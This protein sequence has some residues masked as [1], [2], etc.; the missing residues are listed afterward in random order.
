MSKHIWPLCPP[1]KA[2]IND[3]IHELPD[4]DVENSDILQ[5]ISLPQVNVLVVMTPARVLAYNLKPLALVAAH[6]RS[7][8][9]I[10]EFGLNRSLT[11]S[12]ALDRDVEGLLSK[13]ESYSI[14]W[15]QGKMVFYV[16]TDRNFILTYQILKGSTNLATFKDY[17]IPVIDTQ[18]VRDDIDQDYDDALDNDTLTV[19]EK[20]KT[21]RI[22]QNGY[23]VRKDK[24]FLQFLAVKQ[25]DVDELPVRKL[26][27]RLKVVLKFDHNITDLFGFKRSIEGNYGKAEESL[28]VLFP[29]GL[30]LLS[31]EDFKLKRT[32]LVEVLNG[33]KICLNDGHVSVISKDSDEKDTIINTVIFSNQSIESTKL[34]DPGTFLSCFELGKR[35]VLLFEDKVTF[36]NTI[37]KE[38]DHAFDVPFKVKLGGKMN[39]QILLLISS[40]NS[41]HFITPYGNSIF[42]SSADSDLGKAPKTLD[43]SDFAYVDKL[44]IIVSHSGDYEMWDLWEEA[45]QTPSDSRSPASYVLHNNNNDIAIYSPLGSSPMRNDFMQMIKLPTKTINNCVPLIKVSSD[46]RLMAVY[47]SNKNMLLI[48][49]LETNVWYNFADLAVVDMH[50][51][52]SSYLLCQIKKEDGA[53][54]VQCFRFHLQDLDTSDIV[55]YRVWEHEIPASVAVVK[56]QVNVSNKYRLLKIKSRESAE[57]EKYA[58]K[59]Y[60]TAEIIIIAGKEVSIIA[61]LSIIHPSGVNIIKKFHEQTK[62]EVP[63]LTAAGSI[64]WMSSFKEGLL[65]YYDNKIMRIGALNAESPQEEI[66]LQNVE[67]IIDF[68][69]DEVYLVSKTQKLFYKL[70]DLWEGKPPMLSIPLEDDFYPISISS[71]TTTTHGLNCVYHDNYAKLVI[72][73]KI[74]LDRIITAKMEQN[75]S[76]K[77]ILAEFGLIRHYKFALEKILS[78]KIL[79]NEPLDQI[80]ELIK[81]CDSP[82]DSD[83]GLHASQSGT[84]EIVSNCLRK[85]E[86]KHWNQLFTSLRM[87]PRDLLAKCLEGNDAKILG[88]LLLVFLNYDAE[89]V[90]DLRNDQIPEE[91]EETRN[92]SEFP[93]SSVADLIRDQEMMLRVLRLL[94]TSAANAIDSAKAADSW[95]MCFQ[96][97][98]LLKEL[99]KENNTQLV[100]QALDMLQ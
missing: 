39:E 34:E 22:I 60:R 73:H 69:S 84:L 32:S 7:P 77:D 9:S 17:G 18:K 14:A 2:R 57:L 99:D 80:V 62:V 6:E 67:R 78:L 82:P 59:F 58:E 49:N 88:V 63:F 90:D 94:V 10:S 75:V 46:L 27:L 96:L 31:L 12:L 54:A 85:I 56:V 50:W 38:V 76:P 11:Q 8:E 25:D 16:V 70:D 29:H 68:V 52:G 1:Q 4:C 37:S 87:T 79:A 3:C 28:L 43:Y 42:S 74:Y 64:E 30:Q 24:G 93:D 48:Q 36:F 15:N 35:L 21:S 89:L 91:E 13:D 66:L 47:V 81:L 83:T 65:Y 26:E 51:L 72:K 20:N 55:K 92:G 41:I 33:M 23:T 53:T 100:Q 5:T 40:T 86:T 71:E 95:D 97:M 44:L 98:R 61:I 19:F 45:R